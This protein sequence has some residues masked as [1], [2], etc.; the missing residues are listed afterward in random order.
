MTNL[1]L[2]AETAVLTLVAYLLGCIFG[3]VARRVLHAGRG[4]RQVTAAPLVASSKDKLQQ[5]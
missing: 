5:R 4:T 3:Y 2:V 1:P